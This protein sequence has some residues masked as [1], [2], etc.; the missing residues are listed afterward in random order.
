ML[1]KRVTAFAVALALLFLALTGCMRIVNGGAVGG[2]ASIAGGFVA[3]HRGRIRP[4]ADHPAPDDLPVAR[5]VPIDVVGRLAGCRREIHRR[6]T[7]RTDALFELADALL[8]GGGPAKTLA[9][10][11]GPSGSTGSRPASASDSDSSI[12][13]RVIRSVRRIQPRCRTRAWSWRTRRLTTA[14]G[15]F[16]ASRR[17]AS[18]PTSP[19][20]TAARTS[21]SSEVMAPEASSGT[22]SDQSK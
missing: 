13:G 6:L 11:G 16:P 4:D 9:D 17:A 1:T 22:D 7:A 21:P 10:S 20:R 8:C 5:A 12:R 18:Q 14:G 3:V 15:Q 2:A 19:R